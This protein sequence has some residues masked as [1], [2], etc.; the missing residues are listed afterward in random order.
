MS[1][2]RKEKFSAEEI[3]RAWRGSAAEAAWRREHDARVRAQVQEAARRAGADPYGAAI[4]IEDV[5]ER[6]WERGVLGAVDE[7]GSRNE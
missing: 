2:D 5:L 3:R 7:E 4:T 6:L 1:D